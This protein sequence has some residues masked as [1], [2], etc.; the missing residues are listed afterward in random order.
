MEL[1]LFTIKRLN[2]TEPFRLI[3]LL[4][5]LYLSLRIIKIGWY[6]HNSI[7]HHKAQITLCKREPI[8]SNEH[9]FMFIHYSLYLF[10]IYNNYFLE[11]SWKYC[12]NILKR[13]LPAVSFIFINIK[14]PTWLGEY[15]FPWAS[16]QASPL[17]ARTIL[18]G[19]FFLQIKKQLFFHYT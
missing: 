3:R 7:L 19:T 15:S 18:Y 14:A 1:S 10:F 16:I 6:S 13:L 4:C 12:L 5:S 11:N 8:N 9:T 17:D 2:K